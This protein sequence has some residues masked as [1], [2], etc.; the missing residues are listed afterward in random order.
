M[1]ETYLPRWLTIGGTFQDRQTLQFTSKYYV[2][3]AGG[4]QWDLLPFLQSLCDHRKR[5]IVLHR[6]KKVKL[7]PWGVFSLAM[8]LDMEAANLNSRRAQQHFGHHWGL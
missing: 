4:V 6:E 2:M 1:A 7:V 3:G 5:R 8:G